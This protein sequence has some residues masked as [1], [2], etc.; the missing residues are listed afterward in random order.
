MS[1]SRKQGRW[2]GV[3]PV[4]RHCLAT[5]HCR[6][7]YLLAHSITTYYAKNIRFCRKL[8]KWSVI[9][10]GL[11][12]QVF[13]NCD[14]RDGGGQGCCCTPT[15]ATAHCPVP[16]PHLRDDPGGCFSLSLMVCNR[17]KAPIQH[18]HESS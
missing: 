2:K 17:D 4:S 6:G 15:Q 3:I 12:H 1:G 8:R 11:N 18:S 9:L 14:R 16:S 10:Q 13:E 7:G 5:L